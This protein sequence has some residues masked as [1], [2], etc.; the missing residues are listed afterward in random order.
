MSA[1]GVHNEPLVSFFNWDRDAHD[2]VPL[3]VA[4]INMLYIVLSEYFTGDIII[5]MFNSDHNVQR[6]SN[7]DK[8]F[9]NV[10]EIILL[11]QNDSHCFSTT[12][13]KST[14]IG[15]LFILPNFI[16]GFAQLV[17]PFGVSLGLARTLHIVLLLVDVDFIFLWIEL[18][19]LLYYIGSNHERWLIHIT[20]VVEKCRGCFR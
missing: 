15:P 3:P 16:S 6:W 14:R 17:V 19:L 1:P 8:D 10:T 5:I 11:I 4:T 13:G 2:V 18:D 9:V 20:V 7:D 12:S